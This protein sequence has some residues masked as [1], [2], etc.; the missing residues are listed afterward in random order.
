MVDLYMPVLSASH[1]TSSRKDMQKRRQIEADL[2]EK[3]ISFVF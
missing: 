3:D 2:R 1:V